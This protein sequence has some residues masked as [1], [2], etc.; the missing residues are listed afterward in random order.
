MLTHERI[1]A[2]VHPSFVKPNYKSEGMETLFLM[3]HF[4]YTGPKSTLTGLVAM[5][6]A[7]LQC[8][9]RSRLY[10]DEKNKK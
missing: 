1:A 6:P 4:P 3:L 9:Q 8:V 7:L 10:R 2:K 5:E